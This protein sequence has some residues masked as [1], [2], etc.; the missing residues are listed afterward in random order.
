MHR[1]SKMG[2]RFAVIHLVL[3]FVL[4]QVMHLMYIVVGLGLLFPGVEICAQTAQLLL[5]IYCTTDII[6]LML[7]HTH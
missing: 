3:L 7:I 4:V 2:D 6:E 5:S 1:D